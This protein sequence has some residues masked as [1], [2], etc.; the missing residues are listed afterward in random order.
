[1][2]EEGLKNQGYALVSVSADIAL[3]IDEINI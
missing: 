1:M 3:V 2:F